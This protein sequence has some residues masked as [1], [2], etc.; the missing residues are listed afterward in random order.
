[1]NRLGGTRLAPLCFDSV[2]VLR[3]AHLDLLRVGIHDIIAQARRGDPWPPGHGSHTPAT[4]R[5]PAGQPMHVTAPSPVELLEVP[6]EIDEKT[7]RKRF[8][9]DSEIHLRTIVE[10][11]NQTESFDAATVEEVV[12]SYMQSHELGFGAVFPLLRIALSGTLKGP[13][14]FAIFEILGRE[15][16]CKRMIE[17]IER[18]KGIAS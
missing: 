12:K 3:R 1:M 6:E 10:K 2:Y 5:V 7:V 15:E 14:L 16:S 11:L 4:S 17:A 13:D 9:E 18:F 8:K